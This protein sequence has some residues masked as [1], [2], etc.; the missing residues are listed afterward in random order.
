MSEERSFERFVADHVAGTAGDARLPDDFYDDIHSIVSRTRRRPDW[1]A[2]IKEPPMRIDSTLGVGSPIA[3]VAA[4]VITT[5]LL[6]LLSIGALVVGAQS[7]TPDAPEAGAISFFTGTGPT[8]ACQI[9]RP[10]EET[11]GDVLQQRGE[12]WG[13]QAWTVSDPRFSGTAKT[14]WNMDSAPRAG[15]SGAIISALFRIEN[16][17]G[18]W[19]GVLTELELGGQ[20]RGSAGWFTGE[21]AYE[22]LAAYI[23]NTDDDTDNIWG[24]IR[25]DDGFGPPTAFAD[26]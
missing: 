23:I 10:T 16:E 5:L 26:D 25:P 24:V 18:A 8:D 6:T 15:G 4:I 11:V 2:L 22:G 13:C 14:I 17:A 7:P 20:F 1:L 9:A 21:G 12:S 3:R 19:E